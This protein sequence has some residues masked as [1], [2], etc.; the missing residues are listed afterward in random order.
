MELQY[1]EQN[2]SEFTIVATV[3]KPRDLTCSDSYLFGNT[4]TIHFETFATHGTHTLKF[5]ATGDDAITDL[6]ANGI[7]TYLF[8]EHLKDELLSV[9]TSVKAFVGGLGMHGKIPLFDPA[10]PEYMEE[11]NKEFLKW[12]IGFDLVERPTQKVEIDES[13][14]QSG[15]Y[16]AVTR[17]DGLDPII[18]YGTGSHSGHSVVALRMDGELFITE[19]QDAWYWPTHR[20][21]RTPFKQ[22]L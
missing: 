9:W 20:I 6:K 12:S 14:V 19:S 5:K 1:D 13:Y 4:E 15:D 21:Q 7:E 11:V 17:L 22:W 18:M 10:V 3:E 16:F 2:P 8:C